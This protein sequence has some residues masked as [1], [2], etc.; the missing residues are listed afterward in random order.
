MQ[1]KW[2]HD[3]IYLA[4]MFAVRGFMLVAFILFVVF[5]LQ[6]GE[7]NLIHL[8]LAGFM[9]LWGAV[10]CLLLRTRR[11]A[12][13]PDW[14]IWH[15]LTDVLMLTMLLYVS[16]GYTNPLIS[17]YLFPV[18]IAG[19]M[20]P[21]RSAWLIG[22]IIIVT[23]TLLLKFYVPVSLFGSGHTASAGFHMHLVGMWL[24]FAL[25]VLM[26]VSVVVRMADQRRRHERQLSEFRQRAIRDR[27][28]LALGAQ[29]ASDAH[30]LGTPVNSLLLLLDQWDTTKLDERDLCRIEKMRQQLSH[31]R[32]VLNRLSQRANALCTPTES[33]IHVDD[34][35][36]EAV[37]QWCNLHPDLT[38]RTKIQEGKAPITSP[39]PL[40]EQ[41]IFL[42]LDNAREAGANSAIVQL[43]WTDEMFH[44]RICDNGPGFDT[45]LLSQIGMSPVTDKSEGR[46]IG[47]YMLCYMMDNMGGR[48]T[49]FNDREGGAC[50]ELAYPMGEETKWAN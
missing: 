13:S 35:V 39:D 23:Y 18:L 9:V 36:R 31:C 10:S 41:A 27:N 25:S 1:K 2:N 43:S 29:A 11:K 34:I 8:A 28:M 20:L 17:L 42:L 26:I 38:V 19:L 37:Q 22:A 21:R 45:S 4:Q 16:G 15:I 30:E 24:T 12:T 14:L 33:L 44:L 7:K 48:F 40:L 47:L 6:S 3:S 50:V 49:A 46:G 32:H 5:E